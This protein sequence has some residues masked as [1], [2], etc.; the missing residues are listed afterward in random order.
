MTTLR[1]R[2]VADFAPRT[3]LCVTA[4]QTPLVLPAPA[5]GDSLSGEGL[6]IRTAE[7][8]ALNGRIHA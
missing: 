1:V 5:K 8:R 3:V 4:K 7:R 2:K 6:R